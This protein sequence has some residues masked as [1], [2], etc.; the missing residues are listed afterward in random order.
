MVRTVVPFAL[1]S[2]FAPNITQPLLTGNGCN[3]LFVA[4]TR[5]GVECRMRSCEMLF[6]WAWSMD[7]FETFCQAQG[8]L[9]VLVCF[10]LQHSIFPLF[11]P[12]N[13]MLTQTQIGASEGLTWGKNQK[14]MFHSILQFKQELDLW[15]FSPTSK[16]KHLA[17]QSIL[18]ELFSG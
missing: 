6:T 11:F 15:T 1:P 14:Q 13:K 4:C 5:I 17:T 10:L 9:P 8:K 7:E 12:G 18:A 16:G 2:N 3:G